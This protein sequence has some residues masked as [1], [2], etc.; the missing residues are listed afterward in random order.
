MLRDSQAFL[1]PHA[2]AVTVGYRG[3]CTCVAL[4]PDRDIVT[5]SPAVSHVLLELE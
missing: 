5:D 3:D 2:Y 1:L 4:L